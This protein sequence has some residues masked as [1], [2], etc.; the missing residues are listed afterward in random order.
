MEKIYNLSETFTN[1]KGLEFK[2][3]R[4][5][6][7]VE[8]YKKIIIFKHTSLSVLVETPDTRFDSPLSTFCENVVV[9]DLVEETTLKRI[10][11]DK[12]A[13]FKR[14][15]TA[16]PIY[17]KGLFRKITNYKVTEWEYYWK[18]AKVSYLTNSYIIQEPKEYNQTIVVG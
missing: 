1:S 18:T 15:K 11:F 17:K 14:I 3:T 13:Y 8:D 7:G 10:S 2:L 12:T 5:Y 9:E 4:I 6:S 16:C